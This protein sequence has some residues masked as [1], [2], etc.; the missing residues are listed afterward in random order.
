MELVVASHD[1][2]CSTLILGSL[3]DLSEHPWTTSTPIGL[4]RLKDA[5]EKF[6]E[7]KAEYFEDHDEPPFSSYAY[8]MATTTPKQEKANKFLEEVGF[9]KTGPTYNSKN[10]TKVFFWSCPVPKI[11]EYIRNKESQDGGM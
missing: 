7:E 6:N 5:I 1:Y 11:L 10:G 8:V 3:F 4:E 2:A 9:T